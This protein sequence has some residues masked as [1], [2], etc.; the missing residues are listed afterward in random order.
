MGWTLYWPRDVRPY[1]RFERSYGTV[2]IENDCGRL[3][4]SLKLPTLC[5]VCLEILYKLDV[6]LRSTVYTICMLI[7]EYT[8]QACVISMT[9]VPRTCD[10][11]ACK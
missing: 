9:S 4:F 2:V 11:H 6:I 5:T 10:I 7:I 8:I 1:I 3:K